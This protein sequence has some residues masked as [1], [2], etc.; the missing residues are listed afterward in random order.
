MNTADSSILNVPDVPTKPWHLYLLLCRNGALYAGITNDVDARV[1]THMKGKGAKY[2]R[3]NPPVKLIGSR[4]YA[5]K[6]SAARGEWEIR[7]LSA[8]NKPAFLLQ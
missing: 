5:D 2:T 3:A 8:K 4:Q 7:Q 6:S 1:A